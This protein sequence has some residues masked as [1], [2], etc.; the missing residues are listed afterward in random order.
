M[1]FHGYFLPDADAATAD[2]RA[3]LPANGYIVLP[4]GEVSFAVGEV[5]NVIQT[6]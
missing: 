2:L 6:G 3:L 5:A 1:R 4:P